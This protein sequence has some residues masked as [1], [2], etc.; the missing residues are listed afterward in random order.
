MFGPSKKELS[1]RIVKLEDELYY[2]R[3]HLYGYVKHE[4]LYKPGERT[5]KSG[6]IYKLSKQQGILNELVDDYYGKKK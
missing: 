4:E 5:E 6:L 1:R 3:Q 2:I